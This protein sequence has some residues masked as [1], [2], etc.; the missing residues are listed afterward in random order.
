MPFIGEAYAALRSAGIPR[1]RIITIVQLQDYLDQLRRGAQ[2]PSK[3]ANTDWIDNGI[4]VTY[5]ESQLQRVENSCRMLIDEGGADYDFEY[6]NPGTVWEVLLGEVNTHAKTSQCK[7]SKDCE[8][9][10]VI[11]V[12]SKEP[13]FFG[14]YSHGDTH[15]A[16]A[17]PQQ[18]RA[19]SE[20]G[21]TSAPA[22]L[23]RRTTEWFA[24]L[25]NPSPR[26]DIFNFVATNGWQ[27][28]VLETS[29]EASASL[30]QQRRD[31]LSHLYVTQL[32]LILLRLFERE[33]SRPVVGLLNYCLSG[34]GLDFLQ[35]PMEN[36]MQNSLRQ[37]RIFGNDWPLF[38]MASSQATTDSLVGGLWS[39][40]FST[41]RDT[42]AG[43]SSLTDI[44]DRT[45]ALYFQRNSYELSNE[46]KSIIYVPQIWRLKFEFGSRR[47]GDLCPWHMDLQH[48]LTCGRN[49]CSA[50]NKAWNDRAVE[51][52]AG[53]LNLAALRRLQ[54]EYEFGEAFRV[55]TLTDCSKLK[56]PAFSLAMEVRLK[57]EA[58]LRHEYGGFARLSND[59]DSEDEI[60]APVTKGLESN[61]VIVWKRWRSSSATSIHSSNKRMRESFHSSSSSNAMHSQADLGHMATI[62]MSDARSSPFPCTMVQYRGKE[63]PGRAHAHLLADVVKAASSRIAKP[64]AAMGRGSLVGQLNFRGEFLEENYSRLNQPMKGPAENCPAG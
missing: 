2:R 63:T 14:I 60:R 16:T 46:I 10:K 53:G 20:G 9:R 8:N 50:I 32:R 23:D 40:F 44:F 45:C 61:K 64:E 13:V 11:P 30:P 55:V 26:S 12:D 27:G 56:G 31:A 38:L 35:R 47:S 28:Q 41:L 21:S 48:Y 62:L 22:T 51:E 58:A 15:T 43:V 33:P 1:S 7:Y 52:G 4:P 5:Y 57:E 24:H 6:V 29:S 39:A 25:P 54:E 34:G 37:S 59:C 3:E 17:P 36:W 49:S 19:E 18:P 42:T